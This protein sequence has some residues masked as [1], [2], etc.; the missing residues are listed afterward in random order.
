MLSSGGPVNHPGQISNRVSFSLLSGA[1]F[2]RR[3]LGGGWRAGTSLTS[4]RRL[5]ELSHLG[6]RKQFVSPRL[7][8][9]P[10]FSTYSLL[11]NKR[12]IRSHEKQGRLQVSLARLARTGNLY[13]RHFLGRE[14]RR[15][16]HPSFQFVPHQC[17]A[18]PALPAWSRLP[19][20]PQHQLPVQPQHQPHAG[21]RRTGQGGQITAPSGLVKPA[22]APQWAFSVRVVL[23]RFI[24]IH[25]QFAYN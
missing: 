21:R 15:K 18:A 24:L 6:C 17:A 8:G 22:P 10:F 12:G 25:L 23:I 16:T 3:Q 20:Q 14:K 1:G 5:L 2:Q 11:R 13:K 7:T 19:V 9:A 4:H